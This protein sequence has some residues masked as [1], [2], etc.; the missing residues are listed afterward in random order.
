MFKVKKVIRKFIC[1][2]PGIK[3]LLHK[4]NLILQKED[5]IIS[6]Q[7]DMIL[8]ENQ[9][10]EKA[11][12]IDE[13][14][15]VL[16]SIENRLI[17][18][19]HKIN[20]VREESLDLKSI[21]NRLI[22]I[23]DKI[24]DLQEKSLDLKSIENRLINIEYKINDIQESLRVFEHIYRG[25]ADNMRR[26]LPQIANIPRVHFIR[27]I[28]IFNA[29]DLNCGPDGYFKEFSDNYICFFHS[30]KN[31]NFN[32]IKPDDWIIIGGGGV[33][34]CNNIYQDSIV[35]L[36]SISNRVISWGAGHNKH[37]EW[38][39]WRGEINNIIDYNKFYLLAVRDWN[40]QGQ[41]YC[42]CV[43][44]MMDG[45]DKEYKIERKIGIV[46]HHNFPIT[47]FPYNRISNSRSV[48]DILKFI[49]GSE[50]IIT[51]TYHGAYWSILM[52]KKVIVYNKWS[53]KFEYFKYPVV[54]YS[55]DLDEDVKRATNHPHALHESR[56]LNIQLRNEII[57][58]IAES[59]T[60]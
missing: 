51:N 5:E 58:A 38:T 4:F 55:G 49:G 22:H 44:C 59:N 27:C 34:E 23:E 19:E 57:E 32:I 46:E 10:F 9:L 60:V 16:K 43:S 15:L 20:D 2:L 6:A 39:P 31:I 35:K 18:V 26:A 40:Y 30:V 48:N 50:I 37:D 47:E 17:N 21:E 1:K 54:Q 45:L 42:P 12:Y 3:Q 52:N 33:L 56:E 11:R 13:T 29:G 25:E 7:A 8:K 28:D 14:S 41:R 53:S 36:L 24:N